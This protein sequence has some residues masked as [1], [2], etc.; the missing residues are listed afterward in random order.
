MWTSGECQLRTAQGAHGTHCAR[1]PWVEAAGVEI[2]QR[3]RHLVT[4][5][6]RVGGEKSLALH[7]SGR[8]ADNQLFRLF[9]TRQVVVVW[10]AVEG[11]VAKSTGV[12][13]SRRAREHGFSSDSDKEFDKTAR[14]NAAQ[15][16]GFV[17]NGAEQI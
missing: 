5:V 12:A 7:L 10:P 11:D 1:D 16:S 6:E 17:E 4:R 9:S 13:E 3:F 15:S 14:E 8:C 2:A